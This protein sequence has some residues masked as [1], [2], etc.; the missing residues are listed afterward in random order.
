MNLF[1]TLKMLFF[2]NTLEQSLK[3]NVRLLQ[4]VNEKDLTKSRPET[5]KLVY[6]KMKYRNWHFHISIN[7][8]KYLSTIE[9][10]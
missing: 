3:L 4:L 6:K 7:L 10:K 9:S 8:H 2:L 5:Q 1:E